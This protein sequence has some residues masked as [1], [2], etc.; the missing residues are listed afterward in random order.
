[1]LD[2]K[3][4]IGVLEPVADHL[5]KSLASFK[6]ELFVVCRDHPDICAEEKTEP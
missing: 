5:I 2:V 3:V 4:D 1:M 6:D